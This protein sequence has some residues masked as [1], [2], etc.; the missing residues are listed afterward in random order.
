MPEQIWPKP[1]IEI[2][3]SFEARSKGRGPIGALIIWAVWGVESLH[4]LDDLDQEYHCSTQNNSLH[5]PNVKDIAHVRWATVTAIS[6]LDLC[7]ASLGREFCAWNKTRELDLRD[8]YQLSNS[9]KKYKHRAML[10]TTAISWIDGVI[11]DSRYKEVHGARKSL[12]HS[13]LTRKLFL[14]KSTEFQILS[15]G[16]AHT[17]RDLVILSKDLA[18]DQVIT[19]LEIINEI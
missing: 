16:S 8:F 7:A 17:V 15:T 9:E 3:K 18:T 10:P 2:V 14:N 13:R 4:Y 1:P 6:T 19:F 12:T 5:H 11:S